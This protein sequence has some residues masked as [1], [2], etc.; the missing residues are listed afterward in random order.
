[1]WYESNIWEAPMPWMSVN[2]MHQNTFKAFASMSKSDRRQKAEEI[3]ESQSKKISHLDAILLSDMNRLKSTLFIKDQ[4]F[5]AY[6]TYKSSDKIFS[7][8][9]MI[10]VQMAFYF[11]VVVMPERLGFRHVYKLHDRDTEAFLHFWRVCGH[12]LGF[13]DRFNVAALNVNDCRRLCK[14]LR[15]QILLPSLLSIDHVSI[16]M[17]KSACAGI[18]DYHVLIYGYFYDMGLELDQLWKAFT[19]RQKYIFYRS[20][21][22]IMYLLSVPILRQIFNAIIFYLVK[23][24]THQ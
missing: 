17:A 4:E 2:K 3:I 10:L 18:F 23:R 7:Q 16:H 5:K 13:E 12:F 14:D 11:D 1:M 15:N 9:D 6:E 8:F 22:W 20:R 21:F 24:Y 19:W